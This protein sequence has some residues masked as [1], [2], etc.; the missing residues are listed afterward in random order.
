MGN[1][2]ELRVAVTVKDF[3]A[4]V[5]FYAEDVGLG[6]PTVWDQEEG[7]GVMFPIERGSLE[8]LDEASAA[9]VDR[10][11]ADKRVSG[12]VRL[13]LAVDDPTATADSAVAG[14]GELVGAP[15][16]SPWGDTVA[17][18]SAPDGM[19]LTLFAS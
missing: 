7:R 5:A 11:E 1:V 19:Q 16:D 3:D 12:R 13:A 18:I 9:W 4:V 2:H 8:I 15:R 10:L 6:E 17:R 14:G